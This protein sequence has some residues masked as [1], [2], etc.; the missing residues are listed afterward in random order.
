M[1]KTVEFTGDRA[2]VSQ[3]VEFAFTLYKNDG[4]WTVPD[5]KSQLKTLLENDKLNEGNHAKVLAYEGGHIKA[6]ALLYAPQG[7]T[8][9]IGFLEFAE[10][11]DF[12]GEF[13]D[14]CA[15][16][17]RKRGMERIMAPL[18][19]DTWHRYR[20]MTKGFEEKIFTNE[21]YNKSYYPGYFSR[22]GFSVLE[23]YHSKQ[24]RDYNKLLTRMKPKYAQ[25][26]SAGFGIRKINIRDFNNEL[27]IIYGLSGEIFRDNF[28][29]SGIS[30]GEFINLYS[31][32]KEVADPDFI[33]ICRGPSGDDAGFIFAYPELNFLLGETNPLLKALKF[34]AY[35]A[36]YREGRI[37]NLKTIGVVKAHRATRMAA[38][39][40]YKVYEAAVKKGYR[41]FNHCLIRDGN[42]S[43][44][45]D[46]GAGVKNK[47]YCL[48]EIKL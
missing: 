20:L 8:G 10:D 4:N 41:V 9:C 36:G 45:I 12:F 32:M 35:R 34:L 28:G 43:S 13:M 30:S 27:G 3:F 22:Y 7:R 6:R 42:V 19:I 5:R 31:K 21:P 47:E 26:V 39:M 18:D 46:A 23:K 48:Y 38:M 14:Y 2:L 25:G 37:L 29:F 17:F 1:M 16:W 40:V 24:I 11:Y 33:L 44:G 15:A